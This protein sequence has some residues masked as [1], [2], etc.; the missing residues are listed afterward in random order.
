MNIRYAVS[1]WDFDH[2]T[3]VPPIEA[4]IPMIRESGFGLELWSAWHH[5]QSDFFSPE[6][7]RVLKPLVQDMPLSF[8]GSGKATTWEAHCRQIDAAADLGAGVIVIHSAYVALR[9]AGNHPPA[10]LG[11]AASPLA[12]A[13]RTG[14]HALPRDD[15]KASPI[16]TGQSEST[17]KSMGE[18][19]KPTRI[20]EDLLGKVLG[21][22]SQAGVRLALE[23]G[24]LDCLE[25]AAATFPNL[26]LCLDTGHLYNGGLTMSAVDRIKHR[27]I[28]LH[29]QEPLPEAE[30]SLPLACKDHYMLGIGGIPK[31]DWKLLASMLREI[32]FDGMA[33]FELRPLNVF[34]NAMRGQQFMQ[35]VLDR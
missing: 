15:A 25:H 2:Y 35:Q 34:Q 8:H 13:A 23:N 9:Q 33:A 7:R 3:F 16:L 10:T 28:H 20:D 31:A 30:A 19:K 6:W 18:A 4:L 26:G 12:A 22:A 21:Y 5:D 32:D 24:S 27:L 11:R 17:P 29:L 14:L 1:L